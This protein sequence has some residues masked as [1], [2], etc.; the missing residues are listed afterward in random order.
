M[1]LLSVSLA[2]IPALLLL[3]YFLKKD[4]AKPEPRRILIRVL[5]WGILSTI[6]TIILE[7]SLETFQKQLNLSP[8]GIAAFDA[9]VIAGLSEELIKLLVVRLIVWKQSAFDEIMDGIIYTIVASLGF[10]LMENILYVLEGGI[11]TALI[12]AFTAVPMHA[13]ASGIMGYHLGLARFSDNPGRH[14]LTGLAWGVFLHGLYDFLLFAVPIAGLGLGLLIFPL[15][16]LCLVF[17][18][19][20]IRQA[21]AL[22]RAAGRIPADVQTI[23]DKQPC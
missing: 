22:D 7:L 9:F 4:S 10:A 16:L 23:P 2:I 13:L 8:L 5:I 20:R 18:N 12:R 3:R 1:L 19:K 14:I 15:L 17:L 21:L 11:G 6:P